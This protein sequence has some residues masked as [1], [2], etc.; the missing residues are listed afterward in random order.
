[1]SRP[2][3]PREPSEGDPPAVVLARHPGRPEAS[4]WH[5]QTPVALSQ[6]RRMV[7]AASPPAGCLLVAIVWRGARPPHDDEAALLAARLGPSVCFSA[8]RRPSPGPLPAS[9]DEAPAPP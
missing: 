4:R 5:Q 6:A 3:T 9:L 7:A 1:L 2:A 8:S